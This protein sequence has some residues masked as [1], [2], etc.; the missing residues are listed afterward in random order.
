MTR[1]SLVFLVLLLAGAG[2]SGC[3]AVGLTLFGVGA[4]LSA[5]TGTSYTLDSIAYK[6]FAASEEGLHTATLKTLKRMDIAVK[7]DQATESG[8]AIVAEAGDRT[9]EIEL[10]RLTTRTSRLRVVA[11]RPWFFRD[12]ATAGEIVNQTEQTLQDESRLARRATLTATGGKPEEAG[13]AAEPP[14]KGVWE[15][16]KDGASSLGSSVRDSFSK[17]FGNSSE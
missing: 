7:D 17:L 15:K 11:K 12:R 16:I 10:D 4:G 3:A 6:T 5:N 9:I 2:N 13:Q 1:R 14:V 8:R